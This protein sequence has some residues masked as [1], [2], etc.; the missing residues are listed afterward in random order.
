MR[1]PAK[2]TSLAPKV[3]LRRLLRLCKLLSLSI[4]VPLLSIMATSASD[5]PALSHRLSHATCVTD[6]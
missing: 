2:G 1:E 3:P 5:P 6:T 4:S